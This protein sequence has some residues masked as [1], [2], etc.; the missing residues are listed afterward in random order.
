MPCLSFA[1]ISGKGKNIDKLKGNVNNWSRY[2]FCICM[3]I[4]LVLGGRIVESS[5]FF[6]SKTVGSE[7]LMEFAHLLKLFLGF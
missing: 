4:S 7:R 6:L 5:K 2:R 1:S 3:K